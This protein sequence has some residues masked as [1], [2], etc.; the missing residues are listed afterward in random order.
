MLVFGGI[1]SLQLGLFIYLYKS[2]YLFLCFVKR[3]F[4]PFSFIDFPHHRLIG[5][6]VFLAAGSCFGVGGVLMVGVLGGVHGVNNM[7]DLWI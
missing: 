1:L 3:F 6:P 7:F 4:L 5:T 2:S